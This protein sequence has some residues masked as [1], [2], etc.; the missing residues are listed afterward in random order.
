MHAKQNDPP[1]RKKSVLPSRPSRNN[2]SR[3]SFHVPVPNI[4]NPTYIHISSIQPLFQFPERRKVFTEFET[5]QAIE[6]TQQCLLR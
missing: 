1:L 4:H 6:L 2:S 5:A 3:P